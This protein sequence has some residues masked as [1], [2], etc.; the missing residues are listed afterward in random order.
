MANN[1]LRNEKILQGAFI[2][3]FLVKLT[4]TGTLIIFATS[5]TNFIN[6]P[7]IYG[8]LILGSSSLNFVIKFFTFML[9]MFLKKKFHNYEYVRKYKPLFTFFIVDLASYA[10]AISLYTFI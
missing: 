7:V 8:W 1:Q 5:C 2:F 3:F 4:F 9:L 10:L 6:A